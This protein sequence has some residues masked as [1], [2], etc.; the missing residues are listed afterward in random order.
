MNFIYL[1]KLPSLKEKLMEDIDYFY[2]LPL[3]YKTQEICEFAFNIDPTVFPAIP[4]AYHNEDMAHYILE[5]HRDLVRFS[6]YFDDVLIGEL[7]L[8]DPSFLNNVPNESY[9]QRI[10]EYLINLTQPHHFATL[11][12]V[13][14]NYL[15]LPENRNLVKIA[16]QKALDMHCKV[17]A[18][19]LESHCQAH[20]PD[21]LL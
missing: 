12:L 14:G 20:I 1:L 3:K 2:K 5:H 6:Y 4:A 9:N 13:L 10:V 7:G 8:E 21:E 19:Y 11:I 18:T 15:Y 17:S 16:Y